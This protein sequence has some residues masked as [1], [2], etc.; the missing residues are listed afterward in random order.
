MTKS[1][2]N[3]KRK[4]Y[5]VVLVCILYII[6]SRFGHFL[7]IPPNYIVTVIWLPGGIAIASMLLLGPKI[8]PAVFLAIV[9][10]DYAYVN[11]SFLQSIIG[12]ASIGIGN[13]I[14]FLAAYY[15]ITIICKTKYP[16]NTIYN[17]FIFFVFAVILAPLIGATIGIIGL[18]LVNV[19]PTKDLAYSWLTW[20]L[21][22]IIGIIAL[23]PTILAWAL[24]KSLSFNFKQFIEYTLILIIIIFLSWFIFWNRD[25]LAYLFIPLP[26]WASFRFN[27][28]VATTTGL[29]IA[30]IAIFAT[31]HGY[32]AFSATTENN[33]L[34]LLQSFI[35][36]IF[37]G[38][39]LLSSTLAERKTA[40]YNLNKLNREL[41]GRVIERTSELNDKNNILEKTLVELKT[42][43]KQLIESEK[44]AQLGSVIAGIS[45]E[46]NTPIGISL[47]G[48]TIIVDQF[49][50]LTEKIQ[51][52]NFEPAAVT[53]LLSHINETAAL[54]QSNLLRSVKLINSFKLVTTD[55]ISDSLREF[56]LRE[57]VEVIV[58]NLK[59]ELKKTSHQIKIDID[60][61]LTIT[62]YP[63][64][65]AQVVTNFIK[66]SLIHA[67][68]P[69]ESGEI[70]IVAKIKENNLEFVY[71]DNGAG[72]SSANINKIY[73]PFFSTKRD[74][75]CTGLGL[76]IIYNIVSQNFHGTI[77]CQSIEGQGTKFIITCPIKVT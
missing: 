36:V 7:A 2:F 51:M 18:W 67:F 19:I 39:I 12:A 10:G 23:T 43:Q 55:T 38:I 68:S 53:E 42:T 41:E 48:N 17:A 59:P 14:E 44:F 45:H 11:N 8:W 5:Q 24:D 63:G 49:K 64:A 22:D 75:G 77:N 33:S 1:I 30:S 54:I 37:V 28:K 71:S 6:A 61:E 57:Y 69:Q 50:E 20:Y 27:F 4:Q 47:T 66:N 74:K 46:I 40:Y 58:Q 16:F 60:P 9:F 13:T 62:S 35:G 52:P 15:G 56:K 29:I 76:H 70:N 32:G 25:P 73:D 72:I 3:D 65:W 21:G 26:L 31:T 34:I